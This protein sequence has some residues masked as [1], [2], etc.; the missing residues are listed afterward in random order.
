MFCMGGIEIPMLPNEC[1]PS[2]AITKFKKALE[3]KYIIV[4]NA[5]YKQPDLKYVADAQ[6]H[7]L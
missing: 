1:W 7:V 6:T 4:K 2:S 5:V 3:E